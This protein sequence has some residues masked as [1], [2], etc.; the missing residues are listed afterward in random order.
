M[1]S[2]PCRGWFLLVWSSYAEH[3]ISCCN[4]TLNQFVCISQTAKESK[5]YEDAG[6]IA[7]EGTLNIRTV[8]SLTIEDM[9]YHNYEKAIEFPYRYLAPKD[10]SFHVNI[11]ALLFVLRSLLEFKTFALIFEFCASEITV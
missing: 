3:S 11:M 8:A 2:Q 9:F 4:F 5:A 10:L 1:F 6:K 7:V